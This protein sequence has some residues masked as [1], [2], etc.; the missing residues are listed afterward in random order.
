VAPRGNWPFKRKEKRN[1]VREDK[2]SP[3]SQNALYGP[4]RPGITRKKETKVPREDEEKNL[5]S[6]Q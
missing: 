3:N 2:R 5:K 1:P 4:Q 6:I